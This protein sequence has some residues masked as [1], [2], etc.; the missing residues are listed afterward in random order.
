MCLLLPRTLTSTGF[1]VLIQVH[2][3]WMLI[4]VVMTCYLIER[5]V[6]ERPYLHSP[7]GRT[8]SFEVDKQKFTFTFI[9]SFHPR[10]ASNYAF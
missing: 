5:P 4:P 3:T 9:L 7:G 2:H 6:S 8:G 1:A 10:I